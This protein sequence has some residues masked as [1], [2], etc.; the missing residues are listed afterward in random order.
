M[1]KYKTKSD[2]LSSHP[3]KLSPKFQPDG[4]NS[5]KKAQ[6]MMRIALEKRDSSI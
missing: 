2:F 4:I 5:Y 6:E 3:S 1:L